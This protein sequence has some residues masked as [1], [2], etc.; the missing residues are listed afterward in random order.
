MVRDG[1]VV[2]LCSF[3]F[4]ATAFTLAKVPCAPPHPP[5]NAPRAAL[6]ALPHMIRECKAPRERQGVGAALLAAGAAPLTPVPGG[7]GARG[8]APQDRAA[9]R[10][11]AGRRCGP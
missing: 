4:N 8:A 10:A 1:D 7:S 9:A 2:Y 3:L 5:R 6:H 11:D